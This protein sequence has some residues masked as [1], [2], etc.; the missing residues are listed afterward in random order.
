MSNTILVYSV[1]GPIQSNIGKTEFDGG[2]EYIVKNLENLSINNPNIDFE[3]HLG[4]WKRHGV[5]PRFANYSNL[6][7]FIHEFEDIDG[8]LYPGL[9]PSMQHGS[10]LNL[11]ITCVEFTNN[12]KLIIDPDFYVIKKNVIQDM[13]DE[14]INNSNKVLTV[15]YPANYPKE[16]S[17]DVPAVYFT[18]FNSKFDIR[19]FDFTPNDIENQHNQIQISFLMRILFY[20]H[21]K[22][23]SSEYFIGKV[24]TQYLCWKTN[25]INLDPKD[26][27]W[28]LKSHIDNAD[29]EILPNLVLMK[30]VNIPF[31]SPSA[32]LQDNPNLVAFNIDPFWHFS[33]QGIAEG[34]SLKSQSRLFQI[35][36]NWI[37][38]PIKSSKK[39]PLSSLYFSKIEFPTIFRD[40]SIYSYKNE[41]FGIHLGH[42]GKSKLKSQG[43][44]LNQFLK[45]SDSL[46]N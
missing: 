39:W 15:S 43:I 18:L 16:Y 40:V 23:Y 7:V 33:E 45:I 25:R 38:N 4:H 1:I 32:Y 17:W 10:I 20:L 12:Y 3:V 21:R 13:I 19:E 24:I 26:T 46:I 22:K 30:K 36:F 34:C 28:R 5:L 29:L 41:A 8:T 37:V 2:A 27:G 14:M 35:A 9:A 31:F 6:R 44:G 42:S 11:L